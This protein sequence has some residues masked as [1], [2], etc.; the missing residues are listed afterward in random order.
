MLKDVYYYGDKIVTYMADNTTVQLLLALSVRLKLKRIILNAKCV[1][2]GEKV[3][4][5]QPTYVV[6]PRNFDGRLK[7]EYLI[8]LLILNLY[9]SKA[10]PYI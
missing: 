7:Y 1:F 10:A 9:G 6:Q 3:T 8:S 4:S 2:P 5:P